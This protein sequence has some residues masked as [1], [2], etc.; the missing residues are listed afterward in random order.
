MRP[1][2]NEFETVVP[3]IAQCFNIKNTQKVD[4]RP[5]LDTTAIVNGGN[6][7]VERSYGGGSYAADMPKLRR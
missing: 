1:F 6:M 4:L 7:T 5:S 3:K 2:S